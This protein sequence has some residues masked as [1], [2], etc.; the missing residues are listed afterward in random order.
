[1]RVQDLTDSAYLCANG[2]SATWD[3]FSTLMNLCLADYAIMYMIV[4]L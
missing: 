1:M 4:M 3:W 2:G